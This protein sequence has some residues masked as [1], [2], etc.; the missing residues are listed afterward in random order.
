MK[1][2]LTF[3]LSIVI[4]LGCKKSES[5]ISPIVGKW[6]LLPTKYEFYTNGVITNSSTQSYQASDYVEFRANGTM[7]SKTNGTLYV[8][9]F[10]LNG[11][12][13]TFDNIN[14]AKVT[15]L[16]SDKLMYYFRDS[17]N[18]TQNRITTFSLN[19]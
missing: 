12:S 7:E 14:K 19:K 9:S 17:I 10:I 8:G 2:A 6:S 11:D 5:I 4:L 15:Q 13:I 18:S 16:T 3:L 1:P